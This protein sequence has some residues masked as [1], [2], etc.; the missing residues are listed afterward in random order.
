VWVQTYAAIIRNFVEG[1]RIAARG[2]TFLLKGPMA[3]KDL[4]KRCLILGDRM[5]LSNDIELRE[6]VSKPLIANALA[7]FREEGYLRLR[8]GRWA[9]TESFDTQDAVSTIEG[10]IADLCRGFSA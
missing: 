5:Y 8:E 2:L 7:A 4:L 1:Y 9:L 10:R 3:E 6:A